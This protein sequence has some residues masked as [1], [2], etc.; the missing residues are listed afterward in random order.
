MTKIKDLVTV[1]VDNVFRTFPL[2]S[3][4]YELVD[5]VRTIKTLLL[6]ENSPLTVPA[7]NDGR[8]KAFLE[9]VVETFITGAMAML[10][11]N[12][13]VPGEPIPTIVQDRARRA[14]ASMNEYD[15]G[16]DVCQDARSNV[17]LWLWCLWS[18]F[19]DTLSEA[20]IVRPT[21]TTVSLGKGYGIIVRVN[22][23]ERKL[24]SASTA[25][26]SDMELQS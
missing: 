13:S 1:T 22:G 4:R 18:K 8:I 12:M 24:D 21:Y 2:D 15:A 25:S 11:V 3:E 9:Q 17:Q 19:S 7:M 16:M 6:D 10:R 23:E 20:H 5:H 26:S 14:A